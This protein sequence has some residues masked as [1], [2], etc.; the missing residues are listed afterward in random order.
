MMVVLLVHE[1]TCCIT[2][3]EGVYVED[4]CWR[5]HIVNKA[6]EVKKHRGQWPRGVD[7]G[8]LRNLLSASAVITRPHVTNSTR[9]CCCWVTSIAHCGSVFVHVE[10]L[11]CERVCVLFLCVDM[12]VC[13]FYTVTLCIVFVCSRFITFLIHLVV[14]RTLTRLDTRSTQARH[15]LDTSLTQ[16]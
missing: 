15:E 3:T 11:A 8:E 7:I 6:Q 14:M 1:A 5:Q 12:C 10:W 4:I 13:M 2:G 16:A 9:C